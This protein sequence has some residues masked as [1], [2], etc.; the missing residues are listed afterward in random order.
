MLAESLVLRS[1]LRNAPDVPAPERGVVAR[2]V[3]QPL[4]QLGRFLEI[5]LVDPQHPVR[6]D[7][8]A[9]QLL[10]ELRVRRPGYQRG[11]ELPGEHAGIWRRRRAARRRRTLLFSRTRTLTRTRRRGACG[12][13]PLFS[14]EISYFDSPTSRRRLVSSVATSRRRR[15]ASELPIHRVAELPESREPPAKLARPG[16]PVHVT[17]RQRDPVVGLPGE[18]LARDV[19]DAQPHAAHRRV[20]EHVTVRR[21]VPERQMDAYRWAP[22][23]LVARVSLPGQLSSSPNRNLDRGETLYLVTPAV[24]LN[25]SATFEPIDERDGARLL[26]SIDVYL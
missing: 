2:I 7:L 5:A 26:D 15:D 9:L 23:P 8:P 25:D 17:D 22:T 10:R 16:D 4:R 12:A 18:R 21:V 13:H 1:E 14:L 6:L 24:K 11:A 20:V 19:E 3:E